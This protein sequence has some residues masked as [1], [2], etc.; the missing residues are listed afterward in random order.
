[1]TLNVHRFCFEVTFFCIWQNM[2]QQNFLV[3]MGESKHCFD[4]SCY[5]HNFNMS[6]RGELGYNN[7]AVF[8]IKG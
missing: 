8:L 6:T 4:H 7:T 3:K 1:M 2:F 5:L